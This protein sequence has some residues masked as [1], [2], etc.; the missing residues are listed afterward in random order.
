MIKEANL[1]CKFYLCVIPENFGA[2][3]EKFIRNLRFQLSHA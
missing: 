1:N 3:A 2:V